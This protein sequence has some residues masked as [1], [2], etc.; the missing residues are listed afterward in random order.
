MARQLMR[1]LLLF[2]LLSLR[3]LYS[4]RHVL[5]YGTWS[6]TCRPTARVNWGKFREPLCPLHVEYWGG[7]NMNL[8][9]TGCIIRAMRLCTKK[10]YYFF[11]IKRGGSYTINKQT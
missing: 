2:S 4:G 1:Q 10:N 6:W 7:V 8:K 9:G 11:C 5:F 3:S